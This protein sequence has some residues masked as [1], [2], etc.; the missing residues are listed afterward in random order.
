MTKLLFTKS[1]WILSKAIMWGL[2]EPCSHFAISF[3][4]KIVF[5]SNLLGSHVV[6]YE[7]FKK[8]CKIVQTI[9]FVPTLEVEEAVYEN[10]YKLSGKWYDFGAIVFFAVW[11]VF[12]RLSGR[13]VTSPKKNFWGSKKAVLCTEIAKALVPIYPGIKDWDLDTIS[14][15]ELYLKLKGLT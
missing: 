11:V 9:E 8:S 2:N 14:P 4:D 13:K 3:D 7:K 12:C 1:N 6:W 10:C 15:H 5:H